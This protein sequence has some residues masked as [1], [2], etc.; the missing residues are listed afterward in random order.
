M[1]MQ[2]D[3]LGSSV[4]RPEMIEI[5]VWGAALAAG[6][7]IGW[8]EFSDDD[9]VADRVWEPEMPEAQREQLYHMWNQAVERTLGWENA[10]DYS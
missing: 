5:T 7:G 8:W 10:A 1:Q 2:A 6:I 4:Q 3:I 9:Y